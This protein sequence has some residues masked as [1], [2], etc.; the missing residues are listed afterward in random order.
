MADLQY[1][2][3]ITTTIIIIIIKKTKQ[4]AH[5]GSPEQNRKGKLG[6]NDHLSKMSRVR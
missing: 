5:F 3:V 6:R 1:I 2:I 4:W